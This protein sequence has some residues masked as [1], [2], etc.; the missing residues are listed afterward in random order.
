MKK[1]LPL[2]LGVASSTAFA[3]LTNFG[4]PN[5]ALLTHAFA[6]NSV[7]IVQLGDSHTAGDTMTDAVRQSLQ[8]RFGDGGMGWAMPMYFSGQRMARFGYDN[9]D[10]TPVSSRHE[11]G[12]NYTLGGMLAKPLWHGATLT[13]KPKNDENPQRLFISLRQSAGDGRFIAQDARGQRFALQTEPKNGQWQ[14]LTITATLPLMIYNDG[15][16]RSAIGGWWAFNPAGRG[17]VVSAIGIN[18]SELSHWHRWNASAWQRELSLIRPNLLVL[19]YG[20]NEAYNGVSGQTVKQEL[21]QRIRQIRTA[22]P[23]TAI[24][25]MSAPEVLKNRTGD[26]GTRPSTLTDVQRA[27]REV[28][29]NERTLYWDWQSAMGGQCSMKWWIRQGKASNDG[30]HFTQSGY[31]E[32]GSRFAQDL[33]A[34]QNSSSTSLAYTLSSQSSYNATTTT[35]T[36]ALPNITNPRQNGQNPNGQ[37]GGQIS[38][39]QN[40]NGQSQNGQQGYIRIE[41]VNP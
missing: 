35:I 27:Q 15:A 3:N 1:Y 12:E 37:H 24:L 5:T 33:L 39:G 41:R 14:L 7:H 34:L 13:I 19:A 38:Y 36:H 22:S 28:A 18:G 20:T 25:I 29:Q 21:T 40:S 10:F 23:Q 6:Q 11:W 30:V 9:V 16:N 31:S 2:L 4:E 8:A 17:A 32:L 26:C